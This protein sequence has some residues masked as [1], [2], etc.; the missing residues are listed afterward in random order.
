[1]RI[2]TILIAILVLLVVLPGGAIVYVMSVDYNQYKGLIASEVERA[3]GRKLTIDGKVAL[4]LSLTPTLTVKDLSLANPPGGSRPQMIMLKRLEVQMQLLPLLSRQVKIDLVVLRGADILL[5]TDKTGHGNWVFSH[6]ETSSGPAVASGE[7]PPLPEISL[8]KI[9]DSLVTYRDGDTGVSRSLR[10]DRLDAATKGGR[11][12]LDLAAL[13]GKVPVTVKGSVGAPQLL[14]GG[15]PFPFDLV[16][17]SGS[18]TASIKGAVGDIV[19]M[20][21]LAADISAQGKRLSELSE[22]AGIPLPPLGPYRFAGKAVDIPD[23]YRINDLILDMGGSSLK[24]EL[25]LTFAKRPKVTAELA[26]DTLDLKDFGVTPGHDGPDDGPVFSADPL[27][28]ALLNQ[29][30]ADLKVT[31][32]RFVRKSAVFSDVK[33]ILV[34]NAGK[35][36]VK[37]LSASIQGG[38]LVAYLTADSTRSPP[39]VTLDL[40]ESN[41]EAGSLL[42]FLTGTRILTSGRA[43]LKVSGASAGNSLHALVAGLDGSFDYAMGA[44]NIDNAY[45]RIF[46]ANLFTLV[47]FGSSGNSSNVKCLAGRFDI[48]HGVATARQLAMETKGAII[49]GKGT[50]NLGTEQLDLHLSPYATAP[51]LTN[52]AVPIMIRGNM[53]NPQV[54]PDAAAIARGTVTLPLTALTTL[55]GIVGLEAGGNPANCG[56][57]AAAPAKGLLNGIGN[58][59]KDAFD[60]LTSLLP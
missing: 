26:A 52:F 22:L 15:A 44:G 28:F 18:S 29:A 3:T 54:G 7:G 58:G 4:A 46:L 24:G 50:I 12:D 53:S 34:L 41:A 5:E 20:Q 23:G 19:Q 39:P 13:I 55:G 32:K 21:G 40:T 56:E 30:D 17:A 48:R 36:Q 14:S 27:P 47:S 25:A 38:T 57:A 2:K 42:A 6:A 60:G 43:H 45:A 11:I 16:V 9:R 33:L 35:L 37:P 31:A 10:I 1:M 59:A 49:I 51:N 8:V